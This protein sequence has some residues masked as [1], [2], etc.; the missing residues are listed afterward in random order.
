MTRGSIQRREAFASLLNFLRS[1]T[2]SRMASITIP[3]ANTDLLEFQGYRVARRESEGERPQ[4]RA[5]VAQV[6]ELLGVERATPFIERLGPAAREVL[7]E[8]VEN[9]EPCSSRGAILDGVNRC[10]SSRRTLPARRAAA[11]VIAQFNGRSRRSTVPTSPVA[12]VSLRPSA[13]SVLEKRNRDS[14]SERED[15]QEDRRAKRARYESPVCV[16]GEN[17]V[18]EGGCGA[19][20]LGGSRADVDAPLET[21]V[22]LDMQEVE[23]TDEEE[24]GQ[25]TWGLTKEEIEVSM[26]LEEVFMRRA[27]GP[28]EDEEGGGT[29]REDEEEE[30]FEDEEDE[31]VEDEEEEEVRY[32]ESEEEEE[33]EE[34]EDRWWEDVLR[35]GEL[36]A[37]PELLAQAEEAQAA[38]RGGRRE[39]FEE[40]E[41]MRGEVMREGEG[42]RDAVWAE[43]LEELEE[44]GP[45]E[46]EVATDVVLARMVRNKNLNDRFFRVIHDPC[47]GR[48]IVVSYPFQVWIAPLL[49]TGMTLAEVL[50]VFGEEGDPG[51][52]SST[53]DRE[54][55]RASYLMGLGF[56]EFYTHKKYKY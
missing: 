1:R 28:I 12:R 30:E 26:A 4:V 38:Y 17:T 8:L 10:R 18:E 31:E 19:L 35:S 34:E 53:G 42:W 24:E 48:E 6:G 23:G 45:G 14:L 3:R 13:P 39:R 44:L 41:R 55:R 56:T 29:E 47:T 27:R 33:D 5:T 37:S 25:G 49:A 50:Q 36:D 40:M 9:A 51:E 46:R 2:C 22:E 32:E 54:T 21:S 52:G 43:E 15:D 11:K 16:V 20:S 7:R